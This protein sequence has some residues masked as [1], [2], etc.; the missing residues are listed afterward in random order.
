[1]TLFH[2]SYQTTTLFIY[3]TLYSQ[4]KY[5]YSSLSST[6]FLFMKND[7][8]DIKLY[9]LSVVVAA[10]VVGAGTVVAEIT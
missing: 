2:Y 4:K 1:M 5:D 9:L 3:V 10:L 8:R 7:S 6:S